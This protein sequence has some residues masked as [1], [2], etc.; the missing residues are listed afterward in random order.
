M[1][2]IAQ[3][4]RSVLYSLKLSSQYFKVAILTMS[5][6]IRTLQYMYN[7]TKTNKIRI[8]VILAQFEQVIS[9]YK[10]R[11]FS[12]TNVSTYYLT[13]TDTYMHVLS[14]KSRHKTSL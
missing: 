2:N 14:L 11:R 9:K 8:Q 13:N 10:V 1:S 3:Q 12:F 5:C 7:K 4:M 6:I